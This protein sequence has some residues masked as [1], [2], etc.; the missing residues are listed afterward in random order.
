ML[1][2]IGWRDVTILEKRTVPA[3]DLEKSYLYLLDERGQ[4][5][6]DFL[7][8]TQAISAV[9]VSSHKFQ[10][11]TEVLTTGI[12]Y[13][14]VLILRFCCKVTALS[15]EARIKSIPVDKKANEKFWLP[16]SNMLDVFTSH[17]EDDSNIHTKLYTGASCVNVTTSSNGYLLVDVECIVD[18]EKEKGDVTNLN[19]SKMTFEADLIVGCDGIQ[20]SI[21][22]WL[23]AAKGPDF[24]FTTLS[25]DAAG[26]QFKILSLLP[27]C[28]LPVVRDNETVMESATERAYAIR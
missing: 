26:L 15:G 10:N 3:A 1:S 14:R 18:T 27:N 4:R 22:R 17:L 5:L 21:R 11:I 19:T 20:S 13:C 7:N 2:K 12:D 16:R 9:S 23:V 24:D 25:S 28:A 6:T 8:L